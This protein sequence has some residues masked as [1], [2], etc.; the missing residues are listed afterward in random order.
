MRLLLLPHHQGSVR[1]GQRIGLHCTAGK[2]GKLDGRRKGIAELLNES[3]GQFLITRGPGELDFKNIGEDRLQRQD[4]VLPVNPGIGPSITRQKGL[5]SENCLQLA[6]RLRIRRRTDKQKLILLAERHKQEISLAEFIDCLVVLVIKTIFRTPSLLACTCVVPDGGAGGDDW[7]PVVGET[8][9]SSP[10]LCPGAA[11]A[12]LMEQGAKPRLD[13]PTDFVLVGTSLRSI[14]SR[15]SLDGDS[16]KG[17]R[18]LSVH[19]C[20]L[21]FDD[22]VHPAGLE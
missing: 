6:L 5:N 19:D 14:D 11:P 7:S 2:G 12:P 1:I 4:D 18:Q 3:L 17:I 9:V 13:E 22:F 16:I 8:D 21:P 15:K 10:E 20:L